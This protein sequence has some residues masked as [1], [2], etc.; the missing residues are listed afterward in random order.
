LTAT[1]FALSAQ[2]VDYVSNPSEFRY[3]I[4]DKLARLVSDHPL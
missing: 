1:P 2:Y 3:V 4:G